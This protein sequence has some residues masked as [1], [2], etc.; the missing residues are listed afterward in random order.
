MI[1]NYIDSN[2]NEHHVTEY[3]LTTCKVI[4]LTEEEPEE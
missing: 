4:T 1:T 2:D 3:T